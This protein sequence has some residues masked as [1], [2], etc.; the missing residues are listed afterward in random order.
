MSID[1]SKQAPLPPAASA[2]APKRPTP[3]AGLFG[4]RK[5]DD[6]AHDAADTAKVAGRDFPAG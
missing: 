3:C 4:W 5:L 2:K 6:P 1:L